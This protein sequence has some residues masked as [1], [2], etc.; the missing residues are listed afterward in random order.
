MFWSSYFSHNMLNAHGIYC[1]YWY[2]KN[3]NLIEQCNNLMVKNLVLSLGIQF[4]FED[5]RCY[6]QIYL[7]YPFNNLTDEFK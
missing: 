3:D 7:V 2:N 6:V 4:Y 1:H 5:H